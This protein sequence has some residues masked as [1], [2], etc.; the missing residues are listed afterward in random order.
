MRKLNL[1]AN[2]TKSGS[3]TKISIRLIGE[4]LPKEVQD[5]EIYILLKGYTRFNERSLF[6]G[7]MF[8]FIFVAMKSFYVFEINGSVSRK[9]LR[10][11]QIFQEAWACMLPEEYHICELRPLKIAAP[12]PL[13]GIKKDR[14]VSAFSSGLDATFLAIRQSRSE[15]WSYPLRSCVM[16]QGFDVHFDNDGD[17]E[18]LARRVE[19]F[20][21]S[22]KLKC[23]HVKTN[24]RKY[25]LQDWEHSFAAQLAG[26]LHLFY[27]SNTSALIGSAKPYNSL[28]FPWGSTPAT[29]Y[30][31]SGDGLEIIHDGAGFSRTEKAAV[32][33]D[34]Q[35]GLKSIK[36]CWQ[37]GDQAKNCG[38]CE[39]CIRTRLNF[40][41]VGIDD[42]PCFD[43]SF[44]DSMIEKLDVRS[45][46]QLNELETISEY[47]HRRELKAPWVD[48]LDE[49]IRQFSRILSEKDAR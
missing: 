44:E 48:L 31:L 45:Y 46:S 6:D 34:H 36:V 21:N 32:V 2:I 30:L 42:V 17:F 38:K 16:V 10:N 24:I 41:A 23:Y 27:H 1:D 29:D 11:V 20:L 9:A 19:P 49:K 40:K 43:N 39:K 22:I 4:G 12:S 26:V 7:L 3:D 8:M 13:V 15:S 28:I 33:A 14:S 25:E 37:G 5:G 47:C 35:V 18:R